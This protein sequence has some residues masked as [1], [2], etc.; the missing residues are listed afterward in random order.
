VNTDKCHYS[1]TDPF[2]TCGG[3][4]KERSLMTRKLNSVLTVFALVFAVFVCF[5]CPNVKAS[6]PPPVWPQQPTY[7]PMGTN[8]VLDF[9]VTNKYFYIDNG[10]F[11]VTL[12][13]I[14]NDSVLHQIDMVSPAKQFGSYKDFLTCVST[15]IP[16]LAS[17]IE[18]DPEYNGS[19][20]YL[21]L[22]VYQ[23]NQLNLLSLVGPFYNIGSLN[24]VGPHSVNGY[25]MKIVT[26]YISGLANNVVNIDVS[27]S[28]PPYSFRW[29]NGVSI[30]TPPS[31]A[32]PD[33]EVT[34]NTLG[35]DPWLLSQTNHARVFL[36]NP[37]YWA[38]YTQLGCQITN[39]VQTMVRNEGSVT[40]KFL[41]T[42]GSD[43]T[44]FS[45]SSGKTWQTALTMP[46]HNNSTTN[47][48]SPVNQINL[49][50]LWNRQYFMILS[51]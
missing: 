1:R 20:V 23:N 44:V 38:K 47:T 18:T 24:N 21:F 19:D 11:S 33:P 8:E 39:S 49:S 13:Y 22:T 12:A 48:M 32:F 40:L 28:S 45:L 6:V 34:T 30:V 43:T 51:E 16:T 9:C 37:Q 17:M 31:P 29:T 36:K 26:C 15:N 5:F 42:P 14:D 2:K 3:E 25:P 27:D 4:N 7:I 50:N 41:A 10:S 46:Y 35:L